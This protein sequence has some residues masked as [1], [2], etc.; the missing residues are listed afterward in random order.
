MENKLSE[1]IKSSLRA[2]FDITYLQLSNESDN[3]HGPKGAESHFR[4]VLASKD[5]EHLTRLERQR[6]LHKH[7]EDSLKKLHAFSAKLYSEKEW[8]IKAKRALDSL[9]P[10]CVK[11]ASSS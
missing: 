10:P 5:F 8:Q 7:L 6:A 4:L 1:S 3:H 9:S 11:K 2:A